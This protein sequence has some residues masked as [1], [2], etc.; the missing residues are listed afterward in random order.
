[1]AR[2]IEICSSLSILIKE[3]KT[4]FSEKQNKNTRLVTSGRMLLWSN[5][6]KNMRMDLQ[7]FKHGGGQKPKCLLTCEFSQEGTCPSLSSR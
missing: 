1:M 4:E 2:G 3:K 6:L 5:G 7:K